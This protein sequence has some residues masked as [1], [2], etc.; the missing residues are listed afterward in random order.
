MSSLFAQLKRQKRPK[1]QITPTPRGRP[2]S[3]KPSPQVEK[4]L[5]MLDEEK[6]TI[7]QVARKCGVSKQ[8]VHYA[9]NRWLEQNEAPKKR[10]R[11]KKA[12]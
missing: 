6:L 11:K 2:K 3:E 5:K 12:A 10:S 7:P 9:V 1:F 8:A 4:Y